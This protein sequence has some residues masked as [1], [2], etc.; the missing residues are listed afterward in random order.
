MNDLYNWIFHF[1]KPS[2]YTSYHTVSIFLDVFF[3]Y[4][5][6]SI[7]VHF[8]FKIYLQMEVVCTFA[9]LSIRTRVET[10][11]LRI[12]ESTEDM[13]LVVVLMLPLPKLF[14]NDENF[15]DKYMIT[16][17]YPRKIKTCFFFRNQVS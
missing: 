11:F 2:C 15:Y 6:F 16:Y 13:F 8:Q 3:Y 4:P 10:I 9:S 12:K 7:L 14:I 17:C 1:P 5:A